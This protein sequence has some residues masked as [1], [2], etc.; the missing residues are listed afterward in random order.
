MPFG[1]NLK[2]N[3]RIRPIIINLICA[4]LSRRC[5]FIE[6]SLSRY[7]VKNSISQ[8]PKGSD[9]TQKNQIKNPPK[10]AP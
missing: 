6:L 7:E 5:S 1:E 8:I 2:A 3:N 10:T 9:S 4:A